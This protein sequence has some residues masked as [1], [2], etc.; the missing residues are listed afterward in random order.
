M[1]YTHLSLSERNLIQHFFNYE[2]LSISEIAKKINR[3][4]STILRE[5]KRNTFDHFYVA[6]ISSKKA[7]YHRHN[8]CFFQ[9][10]KYKDFSKLF[11]RH[12]DK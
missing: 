9:N 1:E 2:N 8:K 11:L 12:Y 5:L 4:K 7:F 6:E 3:S 10:L